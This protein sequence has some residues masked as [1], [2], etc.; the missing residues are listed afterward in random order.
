MEGGEQESS[1]LPYMTQCCGKFFY[2]CV[3]ICYD[4][5]FIKS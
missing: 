2:Y 1:D 5:W 3:K 4:Y